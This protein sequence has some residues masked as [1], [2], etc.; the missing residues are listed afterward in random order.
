MARETGAQSSWNRLMDLE[1]HVEM[2]RPRD[3]GSEMALAS[4][5]SSPSFPLI[6]LQLLHGRGVSRDGPT[7]RPKTVDGDR[8]KIEGASPWFGGSRKA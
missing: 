4:S 6:A 7:K 5:S 3:V 8:G 2:G 1:H